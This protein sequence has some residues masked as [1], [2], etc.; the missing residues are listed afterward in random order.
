MDWNKQDKY[1]EDIVD[2]CK[3]GEVRDS[4]REYFA[5]KYQWLKENHPEYWVWD[6]DFQFGINFL[7]KLSTSNYNSILDVGCGSGQFCRLVKDANMCNIVNGTDI[8][9]VVSVSRDNIEFNFEGCAQELPYKDNQFDVV[10]S[11]DVL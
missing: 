5:S 3:V 1:F 4:K 9:D 11:F 8:V 7:D 2:L 6:Q 10:T